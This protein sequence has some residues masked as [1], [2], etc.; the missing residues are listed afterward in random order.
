MW[1]SGQRDQAEKLQLFL[2]K[3]GRTI[4]GMLKM[5]L[6]PLLHQDARLPR[7]KNLL[8]YCQTSYAIRALMV[9]EDYPTYR[10]LHA[11][12]R[13]GEIYRHE[14]ATG[15]PLSTGWLTTENINRSFGSRLTRQIVRYVRYDTGMNST[16]LVRIS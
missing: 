11:N 16:C 2:N 6:L 13:F 7:A 12:F 14:A 3:Q 1:W 10:L 9:N 4:A 8:E 5:T 15:Q